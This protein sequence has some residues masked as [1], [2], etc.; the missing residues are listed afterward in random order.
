MHPSP[1][2]PPPL[3]LWGVPEWQGAEGAVLVFSAERR[4][5]LLAV[6]AL[7]AGGWIE[8]DRLAAL[9]WPERGAADARRNLRKVV[10]DA[11]ALAQAH[12]LEGLEAQP[13]ALRWPVRSDVQAFRAQ[14]EQP[15]ERAA[16][17]AWRRGPPLQGLDDPRNGAFTDWLQ[18]ERTRLEA[19]WRDTAL[20]HAQAQAD[21][22]GRAEVARRLLDVDPLDEA[23]VTLLLQAEAAQGRLAEL[24]AEYQRYARRLAQELGV[25]PAAALRALVHGAAVPSAQPAPAAQAPGV[26][27][28]V[29]AAP[30]A[31]AAPTPDDG[32][33]GRRAE[34]AA[35]QAL[36][37]E[38]GL[39]SVTLMGPGGVGKSRLA[40]QLLL[41]LAA[42][43]PGA[44]HWVELQ[45]LRTPSEALARIAQ[46]L[47]A[48]P[49]D[50]VDAI[51]LLARALPT[52]PCLLVLDNAEHLTPLAAPLQ[53]LLQAAPQLALLFT[54]RQRLPWPD[55]TLRHAVHPLPGL[56]VPDADSRDL[57]AAGSYDAVRLFERCAQAVQ[58]DFQLA[59]HLDAVLSIVEAVGGL[60]L[61][62]T[63]AAR[64]VRLL[65]PEQVAQDLRGSIDL[66]ERDPAAAEPLA[67]PEHAS[68]RAVLDGTWALLAPQERAAL[69][70]LSVFEGG[71]TTA[72][73]RA[74]AGC[75]M[76]MLS[77]LVD[78]SLLA[79]DEHGRFGLHPVVATDA[80]ARLAAPVAADGGD[81]GDGGADA[82]GAAQAAVAALRLRHAEHYARWLEGLSPLLRTAKGRLAL[83]IS[84][85]E[86][87]VRAAWRRAI[88][89]G[90]H[91]L[92]AV[93]VQALRWFFEVRGR[94]LEGGAELRLA[95]QHPVPAGEPGWAPRALARTR[96]AVAMLCYR[97]GELA[98]AHE[99]AQAA[100]APAQACGEHAAAA[101]CLNVLGNIASSSGDYA[102]ARDLFQR[103]LRLSRRHGQRQEEAVVLGNLAITEKRLGRL[104][105]SLQHYLGALA[106]A[107][108]LGDTN[109]TVV[110]LNN[111]GGLHRVMGD[112]EAAQRVLE[113]GLALSRQHGLTNMLPFLHLA[114]GLLVSRR[115]APAEAAASLR[116]A[117]AL[118]QASGLH[119]VTQVAEL[120]L[121]LVEVAQ[122]TA[123]A[124][125]Q[126][127]L[128][129][130]RVARAVREMNYATTFFTELPY[131]L[132]RLLVAT[133]HR[134]R[135]AALLA[136]CAAHPRADAE[137]QKQAGAALQALLDAGEP[138]PPPADPDAT[139][140]AA[141]DELLPAH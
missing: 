76:P 8:R 44:R 111:L 140:R 57:E 64:W 79:V 12:R 98:Q 6:L 26:A 108:E 19:A 87:N 16:A 74:V 93:M 46:A 48:A 65:P 30:T 71:F 40:Q 100:V 45:D 68:L 89:A 33:V 10:H 37:D 82:P 59:R 11:H 123:A 129:L 127:R 51:P 138:R 17:L 104:Q 50:T 122:G 25:E 91:D 54:S 101:G 70:A 20:A 78:K 90:R 99:L 128:R 9:L 7:Q 29:S 53:R 88:T 56:A 49:S 112:W 134:G 62:I 137:R 73:A 22:G 92:V 15:A 84:E 18:A 130:Q 14:R 118:A 106:L 60:P 116:Q 72:A 135:A 94:L 141:I 113:E 32:F 31:G 69:M 120:E 139:L 23:A 3:R 114:L 133:G 83:A 58:R 13:H 107:R 63:L 124:F 85:E 126:A 67:R 131:Y 43:F 61:A 2:G 121:V 96:H 102:F 52:A 66:L 21:P 115:Q 109:A 75:S 4:C 119:Q 77:S 1:E 28:A 81:G 5:Q 34:L 47:G 36:W 38:P 103:A 39:R 132:A 136:A 27:A 80:A 105:L 41:R 86:A 125:E 55:D 95:L 24:R 117:L 97:A 42:R 110:Q 35:L